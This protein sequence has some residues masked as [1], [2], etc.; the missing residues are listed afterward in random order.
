[1][2]NSQYMKSELLFKAIYLSLLVY[3]DVCASLKCYGAEAFQRA[4]EKQ[5]DCYQFW[6]SYFW[7]PCWTKCGGVT[8]FTHSKYS[9]S[10]AVM[11]I[12]DPTG[13]ELCPF[14]NVGK[15]DDSVKVAL[16]STSACNCSGW[17][18]PLPGNTCPKCDDFSVLPP[19]MMSTRRDAGSAGIKLDEC[20][21][22]SDMCFN[23]C[24]TFNS[25][26]PETTTGCAYGCMNSA[27]KPAMDL[28]VSSMLSQLDYQN[29]RNAQDNNKHGSLRSIVSPGAAIYNPVE[30]TCGQVFKEKS[31]WLRFL[32]SWSNYVYTSA[33]DCATVFCSSDG[34]NQRASGFTGY[35]ECRARML[36]RQ[37]GWPVAHLCKAGC[38][39]LW[40]LS[41]Y[42]DPTASGRAHTRAY[43]FHVQSGCPPFSAL[44]A[45]LR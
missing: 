15:N 1:M 39:F 16:G 43:R 38:C 18:E 44:Y 32:F 12:S 25:W 36:G 6:T 3:A 45:P 34:C 27:N 23:Y 30:Y 5:K 31:S 42:A 7:A 33:Y 17:R 21:P 29:R 13:Q 22:D 19:L 41:S 24:V 10:Q 35:G 2:L 9:H 20:P 40:T 4:A 37:W 11:G 14:R 26:F 28:M 8:L